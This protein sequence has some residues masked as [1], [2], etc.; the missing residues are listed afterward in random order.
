LIKYALL[1]QAENPKMPGPRICKMVLNT[2]SNNI[3]L[4]NTEDIAPVIYTRRERLLDEEVVDDEEG[5]DGFDDLS[6][7]ITD[8]EDRGVSEN[9]AI[10]DTLVLIAPKVEIV[11]VESAKKP[12][13]IALPKVEERK[14]IDLDDSSPKAIPHPMKPQSINT[15]NTGDQI[16]DMQETALLR[17][18]Q[19]SRVAEW[20]QNNSKLNVGEHNNSTLTDTSATFDNCS[21]VLS[22]S[23]VSQTSPYMNLH[24]SHTAVAT[25]AACSSHLLPFPSKNE[26][27]PCTNGNAATLNP[28]NDEIAQTSNSQ[29]SDNLG[30][31]AA[32]L[33]FRV[34]DLWIVLFQV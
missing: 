24:N 3:L 29:N 9:A 23:A 4:D 16:V 2:G 14:L 12:A 34:M 22:P 8:T 32:M 15:A 21:D 28:P 10:P 13:D 30:E 26:Q 31:F 6:A 20:V 5:E 18:Q 11:S 17:R 1:F 25:A 7:P 27:Q 19:L 33:R